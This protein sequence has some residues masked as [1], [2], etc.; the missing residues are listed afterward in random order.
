MN[1]NA[2]SLRN[3]AAVS[4]LL[5]ASAV[6]AGGAPYYGPAAGEFSAADAAQVAPSQGLT[7]A[8]AKIEAAGDLQAA[9]K[10]NSETLQNQQVD[11]SK[12]TRAEVRQEGRL[13]MNAGE[14][15]SGE[16]AL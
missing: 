14:I 6:W 2:K 5:G 1:F 12:L 4:A 3:I 8:T 10:V 13:A 11:A 9:H 15:P 16:F 7:R